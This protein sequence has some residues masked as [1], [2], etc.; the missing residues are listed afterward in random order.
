[1]Q[2]LH[3]RSGAIGRRLK[4]HYKSKR[5]SRT[6]RAIGIAAV[7]WA[8][9]TWWAPEAIE[10]PPET[11]SVDVAAES[12]DAAVTL[13]AN[14]DA[15][16]LQ[17]NSV[18]LLVNGEEIFPAMLASIREADESINLLSYIYWTGDIAVEFADELTAAA[19]RGVEVRVLVDAYGGR[20]MDEALVEQIQQAGAQVAW[21]HPLRWYNLRDIN[22]R[23][24]RKV[25][26]VDGKIGFTGGVGIADEWTGDAQDPDHWRDDHFRIEGPVVRYLQGA[27]AENWRQAT[28]EVLAGDRMFPPLPSVGNA[29][30]VP[31][32]AAPD[33]SI[34]DIA[35]VY[36][37]LFH[38]ARDEVLIA[39]PYFVP[40]PD[41]ELGIADA[42]RR[43]VEVT[44]LVPGKHQDS[45]IVGYA[46]Q[47]YYRRL[48]KAGVRIF[49]YQPTMMHAKTVTVDDT[50]AVIGSSNFDARSFMLN[51]EIAVAVYDDKL[52]EDINASFAQDL[53]RSREITLEEVDSWSVFTIV[54]NRAALLVRE[55]L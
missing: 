38:T 20:K 54:R 9:Y 34:S 51:Y 33:G 8:L 42:A 41:M 36:W 52:V 31:L 2:S 18:E 46:S 10:V 55:Q 26:V 43:G 16:I 7:L 27:F 21:F 13:A 15:P 35:F 19:R 14:L 49:E 45:A 3:D 22:N 12:I 32:N 17:G 29:R 25:M 11:L 53:T 37:L 28:G 4:K 30:M 44:L 24:H 1:M 6:F 39:T 40:D 23:T 47:T 5:V 48:L 50:W